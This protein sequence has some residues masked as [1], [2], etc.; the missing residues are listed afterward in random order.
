MFSKFSTRTLALTSKR[1]DRKH[2]KVAAQAE[3]FQD[4]LLEET[5][6]DGLVH[7]LSADF[8]LDVKSYDEHLKRIESQD[9]RDAIQQEDLWLH[10]SML[11]NY[12]LP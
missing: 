4:F 2:V 12:V 8:L 5:G 11:L 10:I 7:F 6:N 1:R 9:K 3:T